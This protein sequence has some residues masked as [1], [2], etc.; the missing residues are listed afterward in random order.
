MAASTARFR[1][2][3]KGA[4]DFLERA[5]DVQ[6]PPF[7]IHVLPKQTEYF[8]GTHSGCEREQDCPVKAMRARSSDQCA[9]LFLRC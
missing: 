2:F 5:F 7:Q 1:V 3:V 4:A 9:G 6:Q 8:S